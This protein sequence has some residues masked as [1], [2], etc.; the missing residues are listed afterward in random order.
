MLL[1]MRP[2]KHNLPHLSQFL[3]QEAGDPGR[4]K[5]SFDSIVGEWKREEV[6]KCWSQPELEHEA[7]PEGGVDVAHARVLQV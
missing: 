2:I 7:S 3:K 6:S 4:E 5:K 1:L